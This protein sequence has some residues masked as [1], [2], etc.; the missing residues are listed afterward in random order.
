MKRKRRKRIS[1]AELN[2]MMLMVD[3][4]LTARGIEHPEPPYI[5]PRRFGERWWPTVRTLLVIGAFLAFG[6]LMT[7][8]AL[9]ASGAR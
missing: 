8:L 3:L 9:V 1:D 5:Q 6:V 2:A 4:D 7:W